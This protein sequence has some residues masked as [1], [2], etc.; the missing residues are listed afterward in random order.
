M[1]IALL[2]VGIIGFV[3]GRINVTKTKELR[4]GA[5]Y[6]VA[7]LCCLPL[8]LAFLIGMY[9]GA[10]AAKNG[11]TVDNDSLRLIA[12]GL[13]I[14]IFIVALVL[15]FALATPKLNQPYRMVAQ[16]F[17]VQMQPGYPQQP[18]QYPQGTYPPGG[19]PQSGQPGSY[20]PSQPPR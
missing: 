13:T 12:G 6:F 17:P 7:T 16:G 15:L 2:V 9:L 10:D 1:D 11:T 14:G 3:K 18:G 4:G 20:P 8:P 5:M 19:Y